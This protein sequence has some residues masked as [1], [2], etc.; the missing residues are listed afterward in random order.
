MP[1]FISKRFFSFTRTTCNHF[2]TFKFVERL[3]KQDFTRQQSEAIMT[4]LRKVVS[5]S[6]TDLTKPMVSKVE[7]ERA[8]YMYK[9]DFAQLKS[10]IQLLEKNDFSLMKVENER[11]Q[12]QVDKLRQRLREEITRSQANVRLELNLEKGRVRDEASA[13]DIRLRETD[14]RIESDIANLRTQMEAIKFQILQYMVGTMTGAGALFLAYLHITPNIIAMSYPSG[15]LEGY[16]RNPYPKVKTFL[17]T[18][19]AGHY[20]VYNLRRE[21]QYDLKRFE[22][23]ANYPFE[24]HQA[25]PFDTLIKFCR[26]ASEW[27][28]KDE[29]NVVAIHCKAGKGRTGT[30]IAAL[31]L[32]LGMADDAVTAMEIYGKERTDNSKGVTI[33]SQRRYVE[34]YHYM[35]RNRALYEENKDKSVQLKQ[36]VLRAIPRSMKDQFKLQIFDSSEV[37][38][39]NETSNNMDIDCSVD[40]MTINNITNDLLNSDFQLVFSS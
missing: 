16:Y 8:V 15:G 12:T 23:A 26:D 9:V 25:P 14:T 7:K 30:V 37:C 5:E 11:L 38:V 32:H 29:K 35:L 31:L 21:K 33:P 22:Y 6:M 19:H 20:K 2:D 27:L 24:D 28:Q 13:Q 17:D 34:Y 36:I 39:Y 40:T 3:E 1:L 10:E 4:T 18:R